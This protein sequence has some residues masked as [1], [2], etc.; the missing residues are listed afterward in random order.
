M[1]IAMNRFRVKKRAEQVFEKAWLR[2]DSYLERVPGFIEFH[3]LKGPGADDHTLY[4]SH[5]SWQSKAAFEAWTKSEQFRAAHARADKETT[6][7]LYPEHPK[8]EAF[9]VRQTLTR[10]TAAVA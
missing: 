2:R 4:S 10:D 7:P 9:E 8:F 1:F 6:G 3:L 5:T